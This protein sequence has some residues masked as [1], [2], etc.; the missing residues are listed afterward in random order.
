MSEATIIEELSGEALKAAAR[1]PR[2]G[3]LALVYLATDS[4]VPNPANPNEQDER[5]FNALCEAIEE[6]GFIDP[7]AAVD[8][9][10]G[11]YEIVGGE[12]RWDAAKVLGIDRVP[13]TLLDPDKFDQD[14]RDWNL[15]KLNILNG[16]LNPEKFTKLYDRMA[17]AYGN[18][19][20]QA[21]M[22]FTTSDAFEKM[23][24]QVKSG[25]P[26]ELQDALD[27]V[28]DEI[29]TIDDLSMVLHRLFAEFGETLPSNFMV[30][31]WGGKEV[32]WIRMG[33]D[34]WR[35]AEK[36]RR[37]A[38]DAGDPMDEVMLRAFQALV[39]KDGAP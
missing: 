9:G 12:H 11:T 35:E 24:V 21:L 22:G 4:L 33:D 15:V 27:D 25:L 38:V 37:K 31:S 19:V 8:L 16:K 28:K 34:A 36:L 29:K 2:D 30:F 23:Y 6:E 14:R 1:L 20:L 32:F 17:A 3:D 18:E 5:T 7:I 10:D 26:K 13:V 39:D